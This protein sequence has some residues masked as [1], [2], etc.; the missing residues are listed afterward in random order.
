M[1]KQGQK[2]KQIC[3]LS[4]EPDVG[5]RSQNPRIVTRATQAPLII[6]KFNYVIDNANFK[7]WERE[8]CAVICMLMKTR[9]ENLSYKTV[10]FQML[11]SFIVL[12]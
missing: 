1:H 12:V 5:P 11:F 6:I 4:R 10:E 2:E 8:T 3:L 9:H 7:N